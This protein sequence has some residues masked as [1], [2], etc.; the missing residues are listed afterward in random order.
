MSTPPEFASALAAGPDWG[1]AAKACLDRLRVPEGA[2]FGLLYVTDHLADDIGSILTLLKGVT[3]IRDWVGTVGIGICGTGAELF[4]APGVSV[5]AARLPEGSVRTFPAVTGD[6]ARFREETGG[7][8]AGHAPRLG[9]VHADP[10]QDRLA[11]IVGALA[12]EAG[13]FLV[14]GLA[15]SRGAC[16][17]VAGLVQ[18]AGVSGALLDGAV[19]VSVGVTQGCSPIGP[20]RRVTQARENVLM[21]LDGRPALACFKED[22]GELL[23]RDLRRVGGYI[24]AGLPV[25]GSDA[26]D[27]LVRNLVGIDPVRGWIAIG[28]AVEPGR[29]VLFC[30]RDAAAARLDLERMV[31]RT[32]SRLPGPA[33]GALYV[34]CVARGPA[35]FGEAGELGLVARKL[36][37]VPLAGFFAGGEIAHDRLYG[38]TGVLTLFA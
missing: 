13:G 18:E 12:A 34:S 10:R 35:L 26:G 32:A 36:G 38:Y 11:E 1:Q 23:A 33:K 9:I 15:S 4:D 16:A 5:L 8:R 7:W 29:P 14:G 21:E 24:Y 3:G 19:S 28:E 30:R 22:I 20:V 25:E 37:E 27:Y 6:I 17:Q 31:E 2:N